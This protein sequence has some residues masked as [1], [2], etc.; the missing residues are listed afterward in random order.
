MPHS[1]DEHL[2]YQQQT[3]REALKMLN[4]LAVD[5]NLFVV[6]NQRELIGSITDGDIRRGVVAGAQL[7]D[8]V[9][10][11]MHAPCSYLQQGR[12]DPYTI[13]EIRNKDIKMIPIVD[14]RMQVVELLNLRKQRSLLPIDAVIMAGGKGSRLLPLTQ[15]TP[16]PLLPVGNKP[17]IAYGL[18]RMKLFG[19]NN[20]HITVN[21]LKE[22]LIDF[23]ERYATGSQRIGCVA[24]DSP[25][26]TIGS[27][28]LIDRWEHDYILLTNSDL[29]TNI[30]YED[31]FLSFLESEADMMVAGIPYSIK[32]PYAVMETEGK[33]V[34]AFKEKPEYTY[35]TNTGM[36]LL[37]RKL[38]SLIP[39]G[40]FYNATDLMEKLLSDEYKLSYYPMIAYWLDVGKHDDY[41]KAQEDIKHL[42]L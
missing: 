41:N 10:G 28:S 7:D 18:D 30:D 14:D 29:L 37:K 35:Y 8:P 19:I 2:I 15:N 34:K 11:V 23:A 20:V 42:K 13:I 22:Q 27:L 1:L 24:E 31:F 9:F 6:N 33:R 21:Y 32:V 39:R 16:K 5:L 12:V 26:G 3:L 25:L 38:L 40:E 4:H 36:Y 17:I